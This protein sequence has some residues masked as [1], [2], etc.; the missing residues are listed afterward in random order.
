M[1]HRLN[2]ERFL[3]KINAKEAAEHIPK[4]RRAEETDMATIVAITDQHFRHAGRRSCLGWPE[5]N[6]LFPM[7]RP[8]DFPAGPASRSGNLRNPPDGHVER[9]GK[10]ISSR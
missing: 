6:I 8:V 1:S 7:R 5:Y 2:S 3:A 4:K 9:T 10:E